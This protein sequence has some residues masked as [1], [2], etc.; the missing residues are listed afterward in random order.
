PGLPPIS[1][2]AWPRWP[3]ARA[4]RVP[5]A[6]PTDNLSL[7]LS[8]VPIQDRQVH[9]PLAEL[10]ETDTAPEE[11]RGLKPG[12]SRTAG[13]AAGGRRAY[14]AAGRRKRTGSRWR[15]PE[16]PGGTA[17]VGERSGVGARAKP[18]PRLPRTPSSLWGR[19]QEEAERRPLG[20]TSQH[21][22][23]VCC[24]GEQSRAPPPAPKG[25]RRK[26]PK[27]SEL[28]GLGQGA[29]W[30]SCAACVRVRVSRRPGEAAIKSRADH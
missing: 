25:K 3:I 1:A 30:C 2:R 28:K 15:R 26:H 8:E 18:P 16:V 19:G 6:E 27:R 21:C 24:P 11:G 14:R 17:H 12:Q 7:S 5:R 13:T 10:G 9:E 22:T 29:S 23:S 20:W 4:G